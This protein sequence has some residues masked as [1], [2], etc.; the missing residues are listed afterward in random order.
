ML[1]QS[2]STQKFADI[3]GA[4]L[5]QLCLVHCLL[6]PVVLS[7]APTL[8]TGIFGDESFHLLALLLTTPVALWAFRQGIR[9]HG[10]SRPSALGVSAL[11]LLWLVFFSEEFLGHDLMAAFNVTGGFLMAWAHWQNWSLTRDLC[12]DG[13]TCNH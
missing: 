9:R 3:A 13:C 8:S 1:T 6:L 7:L 5:S 2:T 11:C 12:E 10:S 4:L